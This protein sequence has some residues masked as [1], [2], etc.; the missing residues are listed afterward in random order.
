MYFNWSVF[1][2][3]F[4]IHELLLEDDCRPISMSQSSLI[5]TRGPAALTGKTQS[6]QRTGVFV[7][8]WI[9]SKGKH[10]CTFN[11]LSPQ[12]VNVAITTCRVSVDQVFLYR[13]QRGRLSCN[14]VIGF[15]HKGCNKGRLPAGIGR[16]SVA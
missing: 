3:T 6:L 12:T 14:V 10:L 8:G 4:L 11:S 13:S 7:E 1:P 9:C 16:F 15:K 2:A 5:T